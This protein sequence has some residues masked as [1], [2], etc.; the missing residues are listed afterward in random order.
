M[1]HRQLRALTTLIQFR[2]LRE[3][4][5]DNTYNLFGFSFIKPIWMQRGK[6]IAAIS[7]QAKEILC[8]A[9]Q[10]AGP[11]KNLSLLHGVA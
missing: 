7:V 11:L 8:R 10:L 6:L 5:L 1:Q 3:N 2:H 4:R 9:A